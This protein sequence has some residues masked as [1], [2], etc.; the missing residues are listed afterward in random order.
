[1]ALDLSK[2]NFF[3]RLDAR[4]RIFVLFAV[5]IGT[6]LLIYVAVRI[7]FG[8][9][10]TGTTTVANVPQ[11]MTSVP[12]GTTTPE[13]ARSLEEARNLAAKQA[14]ISGT[15]AVPTLINPGQP[16]TTTPTCAT[17]CPVDVNSILDDWVRQGKISPDLAASLEQLAGNNVPVAQFANQ[18]DQ[19]VRQGKLTPE[20]ARQLLEQY[21][22]QHD[23]ALLQESAR[24]MDDLIKAGLLPTDVAAR[25]LDMQKNGIAPADYAAELQRLTNDGAISA[26][27]AARL[28]AQYMQQCVTQKTQEYNNYIQQ[29]A[30]KGEIT[31]QVANELI[32]L[33]K[34]N[35]SAA[36]Y[37]NALKNDVN[38]GR[39][40]PAAALKLVDAYTKSKSACGGAAL[41]KQLIQ[42]AELA[43]YKEIADLLKA[44]KISKDVANQLATM[45]K[46]DVPFADYQ[47]AITNLVTQRQLT[48]DIAKLKLADYQKI[49]QLRELGQRLA[50]LQ[51][52]NATAAA[53]GDELKRAVQDGTISP[54]EAARLLQEYQNAL[55]RAPAAPAVAL[56]GTPAEQ[57]VAALQSNLQQGAPPPPEAV[58]TTQFTAAQAQA[59]A[60]LD[61]A[62][63]ARIQALINAMSGQAAQLINSW[64]PPQM[65]NR[66]GSISEVVKT[67]T[68]QTTTGG[69]PGPPPPAGVMVGGALIKAGTVLFG[70]LD[71]AVN[72]DYPDSPVMVT[73][74]E[75][76]YKGAKLLGKLVAT[77]GVTGQMDRIAL[78]FSKMNMDEWPASKSINAFAI[79]PDTARSVMASSVDYHYLQRF[80]AMFATSFLQGYG[81][82]ILTSGS[83]QTTGI[84]G[85]SSVHP[86]LSPG[87]KIGAALGQVGQTIGAA[88]ANYI[89]R[90]PTVRV[91]SGVGL[92]ILFMSDIS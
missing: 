60:E 79:D 3:S 30:Q 68:T 5:V 71:T 53:Y 81:N 29:M 38:Q 10:T 67:T 51:A 41:I 56:G 20:Q 26:G 61:Q 36:D 17:P 83:T 65:L 6:I 76:R 15:S 1:M 74:V 64:Q 50:N 63:Q 46:N 92:G 31:S 47:A 8:G 62:R 33:S 25:L 49:K 87:Q 45:I 13:Y 91:D 82:A 84:F 2:L 89:N 88:T 27:T 11:G 73:I 85:T 75:G 69:P 57:A 70:V 58:P 42:Q 32:A 9:N 18:L 48:P 24:T 55:L 19:L 16:P 23:N 40:T 90:P 35:V 78:N 12:G 86:N 52:N 77:K 43:A 39:I 80:G 4:A 72:S 34:K 14:Q 59:A 28:L 7:F 22:K 37:S 21:K 44:G 66:Q 54:D